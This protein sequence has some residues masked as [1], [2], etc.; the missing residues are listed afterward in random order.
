MLT[1]VRTETMEEGDRGLVWTMGGRN[2]GLDW[3]VGTR[4]GNLAH[5]MGRRKGDHAWVTG[6]GAWPT[7]PGGSTLDPEVEWDSSLSKGGDW[8]GRQGRSPPK[9]PGLAAP[10]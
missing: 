2:D 6:G 3:A 10:S 9:P 8:R 1:G 4:K 7:G 5:A